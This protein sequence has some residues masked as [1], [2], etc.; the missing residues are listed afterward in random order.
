MKK[1]VPKPPKPKPQVKKPVPKPPKP[2]KPKIDPNAAARRRQQQRIREIQA[3]N[4]RREAEKQRLQAG[5]Y[6]PAGGNNFN[7]NVK[8]GTRNTG[9]KF[10]KQDNRTPAG[11]ASAATEEE[12][13]KFDKSV[14]EIISDKWHP[15]AGIW[16][17]DSTSAVIAIRLD[18]KGRVI[19]KKMEKPSPN[20][21][22]NASAKR[23]LDNLNQMPVPPGKTATNWLT[24]VLKQT[25]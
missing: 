1:P 8:I 2:V 10:G 21:A 22:V 18:S 6:R 24:I 13:K 20:A 23:L 9:Q 5:V 17:D 11:G 15:P 12:W 19:G 3:R 16:V 25:L 4:R 7:P 14:F